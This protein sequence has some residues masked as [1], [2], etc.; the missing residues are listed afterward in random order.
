MGC[1]ST[2]TD[3]GHSP[4]LRLLVG[5]MSTFDVYA[6]EPLRDSSL[7]FIH[8]SRWGD[9]ARAAAAPGC[10]GNRSGKRVPVRS[11]RRGKQTPEKVRR[12]SGIWSQTVLRKARPD[13]QVLPIE[14]HISKGMEGGGPGRDHTSS[15]RGG[16]GADDRG[17]PSAVPRSADVLGLA[18]NA[19]DDRLE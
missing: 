6:V 13:D 4:T 17:D 12:Y 9:G 7:E 2:G 16:R 18:R 11:A 10:G 19:F 1:V 15:C 8:R 5:G 3:V 14:P